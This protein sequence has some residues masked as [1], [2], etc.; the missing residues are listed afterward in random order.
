MAVHNV[1]LQTWAEFNTGLHQDN[2]LRADIAVGNLTQSTFQNKPFIK[3]SFTI[4]RR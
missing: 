2:E 1:V 3:I 4:S